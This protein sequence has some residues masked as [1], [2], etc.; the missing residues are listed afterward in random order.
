MHIR[1]INTQIKSFKK[2]NKKLFATS[3]FQ[4][5]SVPLLHI[6]SEI[7]NTV[8][9]YFL[10]TGY[11]FPE[12][13]AFKDQL[14]KL[15]NLKIIGLRSAISKSQ[16]LD[17]GGKLLFSSNPDYCCHLNKI[18][19]LEPVLAENDV[20]INGIRADQSLSR[21]NLSVIEKAPFDT[22]RFH[23]M[24]DWTSK[25]IYEYIRQN[26][27]PKHPLEEKGYV[28]IGCEPCTHKYFEVQNEREGRW[29]GMNKTECGLHTDLVDSQN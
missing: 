21:S 16:Q 9:I 19:P 8:P 1:L 17:E 10:N 6:L 11:L 25:M 24:L 29:F 22:I 7:D 12:T 4:T 2:A 28:S 5:Q 13:L 15:L 3:S 27:L 14:A 20:W 26:N 23:P 18:M